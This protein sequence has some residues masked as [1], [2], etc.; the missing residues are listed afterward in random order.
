ML[1]TRERDQY[2]LYQC[3]N[4]CYGTTSYRDI[5]FSLSMNITAG[6][7]VLCCIM[8]NLTDDTAHLQHC[9][10]LIPYSEYAQEVGSRTVREFDGKHGR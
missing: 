10:L 4:A 7:V 5:R 1:A 8:P 2:N 9:W 3:A 6:V